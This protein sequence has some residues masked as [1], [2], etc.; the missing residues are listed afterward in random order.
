MREQNLDLQLIKRIKNGEQQAF[1]LLVRKY[2]SRVA[3]I[4]SKYIS[5]SAD[6][7]DVAQ[8]VFIKVYNSLDS[9]RD[10]SA[11][12]TWLYSISTNTAKNYL[13]KKSRR[14]PA[15]DI[16]ISDAENFDDSGIL[17]DRNTPEAIL[18]TDQIKNLILITIDKLPKELKTAITLREIECMSYEDIAL[19]EACPVGTV[20]S[21]IFRARE[22][23]DNKLKPLLQQ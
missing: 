4:L 19:I 16:D 13:T 17:R 2:Q 8:D 18:R 20:R 6:I 9:Y 15:F 3:K 7:A 14:P 21:R 5:N 1:T 22:A 10:E 11:F 23:I 12:Y